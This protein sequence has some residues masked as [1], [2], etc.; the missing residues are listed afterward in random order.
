[1]AQYKITLREVE[2]APTSLTYRR[3]TFERGKAYPTDKPGLLTYC[4]RQPELFVVEKVSGRPVEEKGEPAPAPAQEFDYPVYTEEEDEF[5]APARDAWASLLAVKKE[6]G[7]EVTVR[8]IGEFAEQWDLD[9]PKTGGY[10]KRE[11]KIAHIERLLN[12][13]D[14][15]DAAE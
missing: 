4:S 11:D 7:S 14:G 3:H 13:T 10:L 12:I 5:L 9:F 8:E 2:G 6:E 1:M 15:D